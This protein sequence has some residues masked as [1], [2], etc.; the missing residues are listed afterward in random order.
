LVSPLVG[1]LS[2]EFS[3]SWIRE[4]YWFHCNLVVN[5]CFHPRI[6]EEAI[7]N[8]CRVSKSQHWIT[9]FLRTWT[10]RFRRILLQSTR[11]LFKRRLRVVL[12]IIYSVD[13][14]KPFKLIKRHILILY[15]HFISCSSC[16]MIAATCS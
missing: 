6:W 13:D 10:S 12:R 14:Y 3:L 11:A 5:E 15:L 8:S 4:K 16:R 2:L 7:E 1:Q 9:S